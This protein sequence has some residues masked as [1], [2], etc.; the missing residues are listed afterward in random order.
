MR[1]WE[2]I[3]LMTAISFEMLFPAKVIGQVMSFPIPGSFP[4]TIPVER[5]GEIDMSTQEKISDDPAFDLETFKK[6]DGVI[7][8]PDDSYAVNLCN[9]AIDQNGRVIGLDGPEGTCQQLGSKGQPLPGRVLREIV[10]NGKKV[11]QETI[12]VW[13]RPR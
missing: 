4:Y 12:I 1:H 10:Q 6:T 3:M 7:R 13:R 5:I 2:K 9:P 11:I 8:L